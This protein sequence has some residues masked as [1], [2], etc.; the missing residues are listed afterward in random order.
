M[1]ELN[2]AQLT[3]VACAIEEALEDES[4]WSTGEVEDLRYALGQIEAE[5]DRVLDARSNA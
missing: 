1:I 5:Q 2:F 3:A 4:G